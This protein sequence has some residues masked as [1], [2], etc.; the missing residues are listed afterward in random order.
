MFQNLLENV[1]FFLE[2]NIFRINIFLKRRIVFPGPNKNNDYLFQIL[3]VAHDNVVVL[4]VRLTYKYLTIC[5][6][7][8]S[9]L[10]DHCVVHHVAFLVVYK[11]Q[12]FKH[13]LVMSQATLRKS[14]F[15]S[16]IVMFHCIFIV[17]KIP[18]CSCHV[19]TH[20]TADLIKEFIEWLIQWNATSPT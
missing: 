7:K 6:E 1:F 17:L 12:R 11:N 18:L 19:V 8:S 20:S 16:V 14:K 3:I 9:I 4:A 15:F 2:T 5:S 10:L 13:H